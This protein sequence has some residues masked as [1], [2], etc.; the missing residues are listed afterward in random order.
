MTLRDSQFL[1]ALPIIA[2]APALLLSFASLKIF[3][4]GVSMRAEPLIVAAHTSAALAALA[5]AAHLLAGGRW[6]PA[7]LWPA[8]PAVAMAVWS[9]MVATVRGAPLTGLFGTPQS[10]YGVLWHIDLALWLVLAGLAVQHAGI[11]RR[12]TDFCA[13]V[14]WGFALVTLW[15][16]H[17]VETPS[18]LTLPLLYTTVAWP[19]L[20]LPMMLMAH[21]GG[22]Y[23][24][25]RIGFVLAGSVLVLWAAGSVAFATVALLEILCFGVL[26]RWGDRLPWL[27]SRGFGIVAVLAAALLPIILLVSGAMGHIGASMRSRMLTGQV[28]LARLQEHWDIA[29][30]GLGWGRTNETFAMYLGA[31][32]A[33]FWDTMGWDFLFRT[34]FHSHNL[35]IEADLGAGLPGI[36]LAVAIPAVAAWLAPRSKRGYAAMF[37]AGWV[38]LLGVWFEFLSALPFFAM[39]VAAVC[40]V[41]RNAQPNTVP[42]EQLRYP[43]AA[44][45]IAIAAL[46]CVATGTQVTQMR[47]ADRLRDWLAQPHGPAPQ[48]FECCGDDR[49]LA[50]MARYVL[51]EM[52]SRVSAGMLVPVDDG[53]RL[54]WM[55]AA[56]ESRV[57]ITTN[58]SLAI[59]SINLLSMLGLDPKYE[60]LRE[61][62]PAALTHW[63][64]WL[65]RVLT[66][67]PARTD[68]AI[69]YLTWRFNA[70][71]YSETLLWSRRLRL[72]DPKN[73][74]GLYFEGGV[75]VRQADPQ[76]R[77][78]G[79][80]LLR[81]ALDNGIERFIPLSEAFKSQIRDAAS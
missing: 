73:P 36:L 39:A 56:L 47:S 70:G 67:A 3:A 6:R 69:P 61:A 35:L 2:F 32:S 71:D 40:H 10:G 81:R 17:T 24:R 21:P 8:M 41:D 76:I 26:R 77:R 12:L 45:L 75:Y 79:L 1:R 29:L 34:F 7:L 16:L 57:P 46:L 15:G 18:N 74:V 42:A 52:N 62:N 68:V 58:P 20:A 25:L 9:M 48:I 60:A 63:P 66:L 37:A 78:Q 53:R 4:S 30:F 14:C 55:I 33:Q 64:R 51:D 19:A 22:P 23:W 50:E 59:G 13:A 72:R 65:D 11:W 49:V 80:A 27:Q 43:A 38:L 44:I 5:I 28:V 31:A 54:S